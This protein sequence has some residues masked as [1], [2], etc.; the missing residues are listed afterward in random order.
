VLWNLIHDWYTWSGLC[1]G[2]ARRPSRAEM[3]RHVRAARN[4]PPR[5]WEWLA[6]LPAQASQQVI[7]DYIRAWDRFHRGLAKPPKVK[8]V[9]RRMAVDMPQ[10]PALNIT[11]LNHRWGELSIPLSGLPEV[12]SVTVGEPG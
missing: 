4:S 11:R 8:R 7:K 3:D 1:S 12:L 9:G 6:Q 5:G 2:M 10:G